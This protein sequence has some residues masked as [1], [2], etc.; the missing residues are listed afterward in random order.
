MRTRRG[1]AGAGPRRVGGRRDTRGREPDGGGPS[2]PH[3]EAGILAPWR[4]RAGGNR[5]SGS[6]ELAGRVA[7]PK[8]AKG[9]RSQ[10]RAPTL[11]AGLTRTD[12][13]LTDDDGKVEMREGLHGVG[14]ATK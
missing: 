9:K 1:R 6:G 5:S 4:H 11:R 2:H 7:P 10:G 3:P 13:G 12:T 14:D 8:P